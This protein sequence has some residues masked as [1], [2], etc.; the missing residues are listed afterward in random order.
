MRP[1]IVG[2]ALTQMAADSEVLQ[3]LFEVLEVERVRAGHS[4]ITL[5]PEQTGLLAQLLAARQR[6]AAVAWLDVD[7]EHQTWCERAGLQATR[8]SIPLLDKRAKRG[9]WKGL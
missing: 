8:R 1:Q 7:V 5:I 6:E 4:K 3:A 2:E 9:A